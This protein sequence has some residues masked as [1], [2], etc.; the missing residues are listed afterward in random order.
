[1]PVVEVHNLRKEFGK[2]V[3]IEDLSLSVNKGE[4]FGLLGPNGAGKTTAMHCMLGILSA[5]GGTIRVL[6]A[7][8]RDNEVY[9][10]INFS[11]AYIQLPH[12]LKV[13]TNLK[14]YADLYGVKNAEQK[15]DELLG[16]FQVSHLKNKVN[17]SLSSG[18]QTRINLCKS[19]MNAPE[20]LFLDEPTASLDPDIAERVQITL[21]QIQKEKQLTI[22]YTSHNM[23]EVE[24]L[25][26]RI[27]FV[28]HGKKVIEGTTKQVRSHFKKKSLEKIFIELARSEKR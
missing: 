2:T 10:R 5:N 25:C 23:A 27:A 26:D 21:K 1:M 6:G 8:P 13:I 16:L 22:I 7:S 19:L 15:I 28:H 9:N 17:G 20:V 3:A 11:S 12:N 18:E 14:I 24:R 4:V